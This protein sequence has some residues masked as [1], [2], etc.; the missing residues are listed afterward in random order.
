MGDFLF[1]QLD[2][3]PSVFSF[4]SIAIAEYD[5]EALSTNLGLRGLFT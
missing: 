2:L 4:S 5:S 3:R 1:D